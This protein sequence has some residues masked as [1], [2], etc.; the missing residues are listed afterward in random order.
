MY[1]IFQGS[2]KSQQMPVLDLNIIRGP[3]VVNLFKFVSITQLSWSF[4]VLNEQK[5]GVK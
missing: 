4:K 2:S 1:T 5:K 3:C